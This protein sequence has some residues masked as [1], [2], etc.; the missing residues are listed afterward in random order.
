MRGCAD[1]VTGEIAESAGGRVVLSGKRIGDTNGLEAFSLV[2]S[3]G[4]CVGLRVMSLSCFGQRINNF[5][6]VW[7]RQL[8][9]IAFRPILHVLGRMA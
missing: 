3:C 5:I 4:E 9:W 2:H 7:P 6:R 8:G 1:E